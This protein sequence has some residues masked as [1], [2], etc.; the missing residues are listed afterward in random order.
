MVQIARQAKTAGL[1]GAMFVGGDGWDGADLLQGAGA[2]L[3]GAYFTSHYAPDVPWESARAFQR[4]FRS[5]Y[6][7]E[8]GSLSAQGYDAAKLLFDAM[9]RVPGTDVAPEAIKVA[10]AETKGFAGATG[11][12][13]I[14]KNHDANKP[15]VV[16]QVRGKKLA[17]KDALLGP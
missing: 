10:L 13:T 9:G 11:T 8:P 16:V 3:E 2:E 4:N 17:Y 7:H 6:G 15:V 1:P 12:M 14:D 5:K